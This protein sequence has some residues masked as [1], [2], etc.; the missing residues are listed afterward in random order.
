LINRLDPKQR[1]RVP[2]VHY[3]SMTDMIL[4][5]HKMK[6]VSHKQLNQQAK[7]EKQLDPAKLIHLSKRQMVGV[8]PEVK[9]GLRKFVGLNGIEKDGAPG[10]IRTR[11]PLLRR[12]T[13]YPTE[14]RAH[15]LY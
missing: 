14:L 10:V 11:D 12:Q 2:C 1:L 7:T 9:N 5:G 4:V 3:V 13:L 15:S 8:K 6:F